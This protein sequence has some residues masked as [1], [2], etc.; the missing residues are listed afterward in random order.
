MKAICKKIP[1]TILFLGPSG[2]GKD[3]QIDLLA[4]KCGGKNI[5]T[6]D[7]FRTLYEEK[8]DGSVEAYE[9]VKKGIWVPDELVYRLF[10]EWLKRFDREEN[11][12]FSQVVRT[13]EQVPLFDGLMESVG[14][15]LDSVVHFAL[16]KEAAVERMSLRRVCPKC[17][18]DFHLKFD[19]PKIDELC[20]DC[21]VKLETRDDDYPEA[22]MQRMEE[23]ENKVKPVLDIYKK[24]GILIEIDA[25][26]SIQE[27]HKTLLE[28]LTGAKG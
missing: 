11:W 7:M 2:S 21:G 13:P 23:Y 26:P 22:I 1:K 4:E 20:D 3:T 16:S 17:G 19:K 14:R 24:R 9:Y 5:G 18:R 25:S 27:I 12:Y 15:T 10:S 6:G 8:V 28:R